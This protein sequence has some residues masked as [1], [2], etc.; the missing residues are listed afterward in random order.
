M[1]R[2]IVIKHEFRLSVLN[3]KIKVT[4]PDDRVQ[5]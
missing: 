3:E 4:R 1:I 5:I 2:M